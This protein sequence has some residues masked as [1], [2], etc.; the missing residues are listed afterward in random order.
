M[1]EYNIELNQEKELT[2][3]SGESINE[4]EMALQIWQDL[5]RLLQTPETPHQE[6][7][8][9]KKVLEQILE[10]EFN[11]VKNIPVPDFYT[12]HERHKE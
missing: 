2:S 9:I 8:F 11:G 7:V 3:S 6:D 12:Y 10:K 1:K 5:N 4:T